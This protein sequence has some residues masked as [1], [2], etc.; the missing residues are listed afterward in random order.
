MR[1][2]RK[3]HEKN[4]QIYYRI[5]NGGNNSVLIW[6]KI[7][8]FIKMEMF[9]QLSSTINIF[10]VATLQRSKQWKEFETTHTYYSVSFPSLIR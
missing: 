6:K 9:H 5:I 4:K 10:K 3:I 7:F 2:I 8:V 1:I